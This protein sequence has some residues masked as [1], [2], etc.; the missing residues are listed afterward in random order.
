MK[1]DVYF[2]EKVI[3]K[4]ID[5]SDWH[6]AHGQDYYRPL[7][8]S[9]R[10]FYAKCMNDGYDWYKWKELREELLT[11]TEMVDALEEWGYKFHKVDGITD[12]VER[13]SFELVK[14]PVPII[15]ISKNLIRSEMDCHPVLNGMLYDKEV[16]KRNAVQAISLIK[17]GCNVREAIS[18][19]HSSYPSIREFGYVG[20]DRQCPR[21]TIRKV[22]KC[23]ERL[24]VGEQLKPILK[25][26]KLGAWSY[27]RYKHYFTFQS[28][29]ALISSNL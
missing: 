11:I 10:G 23:V 1:Y 3:R 17:N 25:N 27:Y 4:F 15:R 6:P 2:K 24:K 21:R 14:S 29:P 28:S 18:Q 13:P 19:C 16:K 5:E 22:E 12:F 7:D 8:L 26:L 9:V 20:S